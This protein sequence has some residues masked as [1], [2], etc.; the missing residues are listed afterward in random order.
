M[1]LTEKYRPQSLD[2]VIGNRDT[3][4]AMRT[5]SQR[6]HAGDTD[7][8]HM[9]FSG[10]PGTGKTSVAKALAYAFFGN[11]WKQNFTD[12]NASDERGIDTIRGDVKNLAHIS[13]VGD[14]A[15][16]IIFLDECDHLT[17][18]AQAALRRIMEDN[19]K[20]CRFILSC[21]YPSKIIEPIRGRCMD[22]RFAPLK[23]PEVVAYLTR[24]RDGE[25]IKAT[26]RA[27]ETLAD[28][29]NG[30]MR[31]AINGLA[32]AGAMQST[33]DDVDIY[34]LMSSLDQK[35]ARK[36][37]AVILD[38]SRPLN[39]RMRELD[40]EI[41]TIYYEGY[42]MDDVLN[43]IL[44]VVTEKEDFPAEMR[45]LILT[46]MADIEYYIMSG[47]NP[48]YMMRSFLAWLAWQSMK[49]KK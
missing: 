16:R 28:L 3:I 42:G 40:Q 23:K 17:S 22:F 47:A 44:D 37:V 5:F 19:S 8:P 49:V 24:I 26:D 7:M 21:N 41:Y 46:K 39:I 30:D 9:L 32:K 29:S 2:Q 18:D 20:N 1:M 27:I 6:Y 48:V 45:G 15:F 35:V 12:K 14:D 38:T 11:H 13:P 31:K 43:K 36:I 33:I 25:G 10:P 34:R 4:T